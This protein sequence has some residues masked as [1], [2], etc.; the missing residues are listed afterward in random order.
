MIATRIRRGLDCARFTGGFSSHGP[1]S[2]TPRRSLSLSLSH[3]HTYSFSLT[4]PRRMTD[5]S[6]RNRLLLSSGAR[7]RSLLCRLE[8]RA[9]ITN[10][11][12]V[13]TF[14]RRP[15]RRRAHLRRTRDFPVFFRAICCA[16]N[17]DPRILLALR[18]APARLGSAEGLR[19]LPLAAN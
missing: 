3:T 8:R 10:I 1:S 9:S 15:A 6:K 17:P 5:S 7:A 12:R 13:G 4:H 14:F 19:G 2:P 11:M 16:A 18:S